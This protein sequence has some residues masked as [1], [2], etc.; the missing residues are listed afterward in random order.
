MRWRLAAAAVLGLAAVAAACS[1][2]E[3][4]DAFA[5]G[6]GNECPTDRVCDR[7]FCVL[8]ASGDDDGGNPVDDAP[9]GCPSAC[10]SCN[11]TVCTISCED[12]GCAEL[13]VCPAGFDCVVACLGAGA[14]AGGIDCSAATS[15]SLNCGRDT[16][17][18]PLTCGTG[19]CSITCGRSACDSL[20]TCDQACACGVSCSQFACG[21]G[22]V[23]PTG[24]EDDEG[25][26][27]AGTCNTCE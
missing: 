8:V 6:E 23:C 25:C 26:T 9:V 1:V 19:S 4:S 18:G 5:C 20:I 3:R 12:S 27:S 17:A 15:C 7:G 22:S 11:G 13:V 2:N 10:T 14:C 24:C 16:C 21:A